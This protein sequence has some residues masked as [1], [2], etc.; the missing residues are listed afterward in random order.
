MK[1]SLE[2]KLSAFNM[3]PKVNNRFVMETADIPR[4]KEKLA[5][6]NHR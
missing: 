3:I 1:L 4:T 6:L 5:C 2:M